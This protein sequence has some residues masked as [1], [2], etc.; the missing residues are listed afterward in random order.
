[1]IALFQV[2]VPTAA[3]TSNCASRS[4]STTWSSRTIGPSRESSDRLMG[5]KSFWSGSSILAGIETI[6]M[7]RKGQLDRPNAEAS[8]PASQFYS[9]AV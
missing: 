5:F 7:I 6:H 1:M 4:T 8:S 3:R 9:L 2:F